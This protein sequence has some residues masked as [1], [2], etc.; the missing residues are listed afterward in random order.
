MDKDPDTKR[1]E[2]Y[3]GPWNHQFTPIDVLIEKLEEEQNIEKL[4]QHVYRNIFIFVLLLL[5]S[6]QALNPSKRRGLIDSSITTF[7]DR[8]FFV[9]RLNPTH[10]AA[11]VL[12]HI[13]E[14]NRVDSF[15]DIKTEDEYWAWAKD[16]LKSS[17]Y[18]KDLSFD[19]Y[20]RVL[21]GVRFRQIRM[22]AP[23]NQDEEGRS[24]AEQSIDQSFQSNLCD[25]ASLPPIIKE[26]MIDGMACKY[27][28]AN[29]GS[30]ILEQDFGHPSTRIEE[31]ARGLPVNVTSEEWLWKPNTYDDGIIE[32]QSKLN[33]GLYYGRGGFFVDLP[34]NATLAK[35]KMY[36][37]Q[38]GRTE[39]GKVIT[40]K[41]VSNN[42]CC[43]CF[44][45]E[46]I[47]TQVYIF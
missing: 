10:T 44:L 3:V 41:L 12:N 2:G 31:N 30:N 14:V 21:W 11:T 36:A 40:S 43:Y 1:R 39:D 5:Y 33:S 22:K 38:Y 28:Y 37:M 32:M 17:I 9:E 45:V 27:N 25:S 29:G 46:E 6:I 18:N 42:S 24:T 7:V 20:N 13:P 15:L 34:L 26:A 16:V 47:S 4:H 35:K 8:P 19:K 23:S